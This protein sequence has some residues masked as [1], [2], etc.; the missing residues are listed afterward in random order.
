MACGETAVTPQEIQAREDT[1]LALEKEIVK[2]A[3]R[4]SRNAKGEVGVQGW[5]ESAAAKAGWCE[6]C[7]LRS[8]ATQGSW[9]ARIALADQAK[10]TSKSFQTQGHGHGH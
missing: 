6:G 1:R 5:A 2:G 7:V 9:Q 3:R 8:I 4:L 10:V